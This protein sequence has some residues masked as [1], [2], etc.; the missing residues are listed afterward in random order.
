MFESSITHYNYY[1]KKILN[2]NYITVAEKIVINY[3]QL[4]LPITITT[5]LQVM[6]IRIPVHERG[7]VRAGEGRGRGEEV[8]GGLRDGG[9]VHDCP[10]IFICL[11]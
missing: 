8:E 4:Q 6:Y 3:G 7:R 1:S 11:H 2:F 10:I 9:S 5:T